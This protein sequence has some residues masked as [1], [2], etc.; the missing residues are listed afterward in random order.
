[1][2]NNKIGA[3]ALPFCSLINHSCNPNVS[4]ITTKECTII[5]ALVPIEKDSQVIIYFLVFKSCNLYV[6]M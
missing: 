3:T 4:R 6:F 5:F 2:E 1:M